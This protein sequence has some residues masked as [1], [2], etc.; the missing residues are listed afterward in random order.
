MPFVAEYNTVKSAMLELPYGK[1]GFQ[2]FA[3]VAHGISIVDTEKGDSCSFG[4]EQSYQT[5][6]YPFN[7]FQIVYYP[8]HDTPHRQIFAGTKYSDR[9]NGYYDIGGWVSTD[10]KPQLLK[11]N[12][13]LFGYVGVKKSELHH[14]TVRARIRVFIDDFNIRHQKNYWKIQNF[15]AQYNAIQEQEAR[16]QQAVAQAENELAKLTRLR[17]Q[18]ASKATLKA[19]DALLHINRLIEFITQG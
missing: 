5:S 13:T 1:P 4:A 8:Q 19:E 3:L 15:I 11:S 7:P 16:H 9:G 10:S 14:A 2:Y 18:H 17:E 12:I 6:E